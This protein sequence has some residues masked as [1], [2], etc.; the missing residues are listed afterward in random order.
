[1]EG[2]VK[3][4]WPLLAIRVSTAQVPLLYPDSASLTQTFPAP[5]EAVGAM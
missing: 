4:C 2:K 5:S 3:E 1:M